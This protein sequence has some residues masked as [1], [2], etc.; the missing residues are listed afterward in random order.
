MRTGPR[1]K[2]DAAWA[3]SGIL[4]YCIRAR[5]VGRDHPGPEDVTT[6]IT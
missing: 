1:R 2:G 5:M 3:L 4:R 6:P